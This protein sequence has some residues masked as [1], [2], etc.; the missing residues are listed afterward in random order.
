MARYGKKR[1]NKKSSV[2]KHD[3]S[4]KGD[5]KQ[6]VSGQAYENNEYDG[7]LRKHKKKCKGKKLTYWEAAILFLL[8]KEN[9][10]LDELLESEEFNEFGEFKEFKEFKES[11]EF[12]EKD[13]YK[14]FDTSSKFKKA[15]AQP[16]KEDDQENEYSG[17]NKVSQFD[18]D[19]FA[20]D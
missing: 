4:L 5:F 14:E 1:K 2:N 16:D 12:K 18:F 17:K 15:E 10:V 11:K 7:D 13:E 6:Q 19:Y 3:A 9:G 20:E 8:L